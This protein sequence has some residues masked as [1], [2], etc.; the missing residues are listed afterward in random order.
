MIGARSPSGEALVGHLFAGFA[1]ARPLV[2]VGLLT[3]WYLGDRARDD[4]AGGRERRRCGGRRQP[5]A[6][7]AGLL[8]GILVAAAPSRW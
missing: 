5:E 2:I 6:M 1:I 8:L 3:W 7:G 4:H